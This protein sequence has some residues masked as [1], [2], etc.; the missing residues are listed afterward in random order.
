ME[1]VSIAA[2]VIAVSMLLLLVFL[3]PAILEIRRTATATREFIVKIET[4]L[5]PVLT[6][7]QETLSDLKVLTEG[8][9][10]KVGEVESF[11]EAVGDTGRN[12]RTINS[13][14]GA[15]SGA[16]S[17]SSV[18]MTGVKVASGYLMDRILKKKRG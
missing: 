5:K 14:V 4:D 3:I 7:L 17:G 16:L 13:I 2:A 10:G 18:W 11:M 15:V 6:D 9:S 1:I 12:L 8:V